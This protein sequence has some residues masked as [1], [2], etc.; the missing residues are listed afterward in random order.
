MKALLIDNAEGL[1]GARIGDTPEP[2]P[3]E[4]HVVIDIKAA[5]VN[6]ADWKIME[7]GHPDWVFPKVTGLD[8]AGIVST[9]TEGVERLQPG[10]RVFFHSSFIALGAYAE[11]MVAREIAVSKMTDGLTF[12]QAAAIP[13]AGETAYM[14]LC[15]RLRVGA[16]HTVLIQAAAGGLG[17]FAVQLAKRAGAT[18][19]GTCSRENADHVIGLGADFVIDYRFED[20][21]LRVMELT[22]GRGVDAVL[23]TLGPETAAAAIPLLA[24]EGHLFC[25]VGL[26][27]FPK[28]EPLPRGIQISDILLGAAHLRQ[29]PRALRRLS[30]MGEIMGEMIVQGELSPMIEDVVSFDRIKNALERSRSGHQRGKLVIVMD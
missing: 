10:D 1:D 15:D 30:E 11:R 9:V 14:A 28:L 4:G 2:T 5:G 18:V 17:G 23:D 27:D 29:E 21:A 26:P 13:T 6:P 12:E 8:A 25:C 7:R 20:V 19:V 22:D 16:E 3:S 24:Y